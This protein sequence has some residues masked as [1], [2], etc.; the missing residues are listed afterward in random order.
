MSGVDRPEKV[1][2][3]QKKGEKEEKTEERKKMTRESRISPYR[4][5]KWGKKKGGGKTFEEK[6]KERKQ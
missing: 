5:M 2:S 4:P 6:L 1:H 3:E